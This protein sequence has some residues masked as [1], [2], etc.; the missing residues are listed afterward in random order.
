EEASLT[1]PLGCVVRGQDL[2]P[3]NRDS[4]VVVLGAGNTGLLHI[5]Y[6]KARGARLVIATAVHP[7]RIEAAPRLGAAHAIGARGDVPA[8]VRKLNA[9]GAADLV[10]TSTGAPPALDQA[11]RSVDRG[12]TILMFAPLPPGSKP[13]VPLTELWWETVTITSSY[14]AA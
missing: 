9:G 11:F 3:V 2:V 6:A 8:G 7:Y 5:Q 13:P 12:G 10:V 14:A 1:E 4:C